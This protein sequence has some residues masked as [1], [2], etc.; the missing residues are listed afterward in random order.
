MTE[1]A[2][3]YVD[4]DGTLLDFDA[5][6]VFPEALTMLTRWDAAGGLIV[7]VSNYGTRKP[8]HKV[9]EMKVR[10]SKQCNGLI[11]AYSIC[12]HPPRV[13]CRCRKPHPET[14]LQA[15]KRLAERRRA[16]GHAGE[17]YPFQKALMVGDSFKDEAIAKHAGVRFMQAEAWRVCA[18]NDENPM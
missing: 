10:L 4:I 2:V 5:R 1:K 14:L 11:S 7:T 18:H 17:T 13:E 8:L 9:A 15:K 16:R 3:L 12:M 6:L